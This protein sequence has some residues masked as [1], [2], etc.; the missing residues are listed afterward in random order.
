MWQVKLVQALIRVKVIWGHGHIDNTVQHFQRTLYIQGPRAEIRD[1]RKNVPLKGGHA[2]YLL[3]RANDCILQTGNQENNT[4]TR[5]H[6][7]N[8]CKSILGKNMCLSVESLGGNLSIFLNVFNP[9]ALNTLHGSFRSIS[10]S[11]SFFTFTVYSVSCIHLSICTVSTEL[12]PAL[13]G[14]RLITMRCLGQ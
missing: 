8:S 7:Q 12:R 6:Y 2:L 13:H 4:N 9:P 11:L 14:V 5:L 10:S 1:R 3:I